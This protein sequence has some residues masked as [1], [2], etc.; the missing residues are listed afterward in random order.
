MKKLIFFLIMLMAV[1]A[2]AETAKYGSMWKQN[3][4]TVSPADD[5]EVVDFSNIST[6]GIGDGDGGGVNGAFVSY[7]TVVWR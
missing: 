4:G 5:I 3:D 6:I 2:G 7:T 1:S